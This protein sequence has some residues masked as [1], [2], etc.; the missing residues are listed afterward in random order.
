LIDKRL[1]VIHG[2]TRMR[3]RQRPARVKTQVKN[4]STPLV[5]HV[6]YCRATFL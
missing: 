1:E 6:R 5:I 3:D 4:G 2:T